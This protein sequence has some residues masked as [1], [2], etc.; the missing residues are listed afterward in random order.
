[1]DSS[2]FLH[3]DE[4]ARYFR[5]FC[6][7]YRLILKVFYCRV[8]FSTGRRKSKRAA[9]ATNNIDRQNIDNETRLMAYDYIDYRIRQSGF[10]W[11]NRPAELIPDPPV[12]IMSL[13]RS[14]CD[15]FNDRY[16]EILGNDTEL[17]SSLRLSSSEDLARTFAGVCDILFRP[18]GETA[19]VTWGRILVLFAFGGSLAV[20]CANQQL[21]HQIDEVANLLITYVQANFSDWIISKGGWVTYLQLHEDRSSSATRALSGFG[22]ICGAVGVV[23]LAAVLVSRH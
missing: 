19:E 17:F 12:K 10:E 13:M 5:V 15:S 23:A 2:A 18:D 9:M 14:V 16:S 22:A 3:S 21:P 1:L 6:R 20:E 4:S 11:P 8:H 7:K